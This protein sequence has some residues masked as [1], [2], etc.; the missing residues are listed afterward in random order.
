MNESTAI[1][2]PVKG[3]PSLRPR[4]TT[5]VVHPLFVLFEA[6]IF[7]GDL[8]NKIHPYNTRVQT[9]TSA[10]SDCK[11]KPVNPWAFS[12]P[13]LHANGQCCTLTQMFGEIRNEIMDWIPLT[14]T[15]EGIWDW[16]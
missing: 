10:F 5:R 14:G 2:L 3:F 7:P 8:F 9:K 1:S 16:C 15:I 11:T 12:L 6:S 13:S 4:E